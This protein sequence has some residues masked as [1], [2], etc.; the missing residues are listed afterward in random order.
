M[1]GFATAL[2]VYH[3]GGSL[4]DRV[5]LIVPRGFRKVPPTDV[6]LHHHPLEPADTVAF[7]GFRVT[8]VLRTLCD[9]A[10][11]DLSLEHLESAV[12][13]AIQTGQ[14]RRGRLEGHVS[15]LPERAAQRLR[16]AIRGSA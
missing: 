6:T 9:L 7:E 11:S 3:L 12:R 10:A 2:M 4:P 1:I 15:H 14:L 8:T 5:H 13:D 16:D